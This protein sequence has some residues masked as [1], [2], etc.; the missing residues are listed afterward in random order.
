MT[1]E[2]LDKTIR[3]AIKEV[4]E[5]VKDDIELEASLTDW[6]FE[7]KDKSLKDAD[8]KEHIKTYLYESIGVK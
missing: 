4:I 7:I 2:E 1:R 6:E 3:K 8:I 5:T